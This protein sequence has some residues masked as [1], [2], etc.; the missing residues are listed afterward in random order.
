MLEI[1]ELQKTYP[2][3]VQALK[4][5]NLRVSPGVFG[6]NVPSYIIPG[7]L[8]FCANTQETSSG[9]LKTLSQITWPAPLYSV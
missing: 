9:W 7:A 4:G 8:R 5:I 3:G 6:S 1:K 2:S